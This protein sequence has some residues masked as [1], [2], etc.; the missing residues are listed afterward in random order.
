MAV[1]EYREEMKKLRDEG[2]GY[3][4]SPRVMKEKAD[5]FKVSQRAIANLLKRS[6]KQM[7]PS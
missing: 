4:A 7:R 1:A 5:K 3:Q 2:K 6:P